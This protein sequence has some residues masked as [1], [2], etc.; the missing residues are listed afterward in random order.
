MRFVILYKGQ[1]G[2]A[3]IAARLGLERG[4]FGDFV[5]WLTDK[6]IEKLRDKDYVFEDY[7]TEVM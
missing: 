3:E 5:G 1:E 4:L 7:K 2:A 6:E